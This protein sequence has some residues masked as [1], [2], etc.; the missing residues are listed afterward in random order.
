MQRHVRRSLFYRKPQ[1]N[2]YRMFFWV[3]IILAG[4][5]FVIGNWNGKVRG[6]FD[7]IPTA[8]RTAESFTLEGDAQFNSGQIEA[9][10]LAYRRATDVDP[11]N[12]QVWAKLARIQTYSSALKTTDQ[13]RRSRLQD[14]LDSANHAYNL[15]PDDSTVRAIRAFVLDWNA[16]STL[17]G[18]ER[19]QQL[20]VQAEQEAAAA[21]QLDNK[22]TLALA[23]YAE[24]QT[25]QQK[26]TQ[27]EQYMQLAFE[28]Q[29]SDKLM[30]VHRIYAALLE[31]E[32]QYRQAIEEYDKAIAINPNLTFLYLRAGANYRRLA[33]FPNIPRAQQTDLYKQSLDYFAK[34]A[35]INE[36]LGVKDPIPYLSIAKTYSQMGEFFIAARNVMK[37]LE[38]RPG[39]ADIYGQLGIVYF[40][41]RN[42]EGSLGPFK[43][44]IRGCTAVESCTARF[45]RDC[46]PAFGEVGADVQGLPLSQSTVVYYYTYGS[47]LASL[48][49]PRQNYCPDAVNVLTEVRTAFAS[50]STIVRIVDD[51][52]QICALYAQT[53]D[54]SASATAT[55]TAGGTPT[56]PTVQATSTP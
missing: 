48:T 46:D 2:V 39:D 6:P 22:N 31:S 43:C 30:D 5:W 16:D 13:E 34:A 8:T 3:L 49:R 24:I 27:A 32:A 19:S 35:R 4:G 18:A 55:P 37:A 54:A 38:Y 9:A 11:G 50:D 7:P 52:L 10:I 29:D 15:A 26:W 23:F 20:L 47:A 51:G 41:S 36:Q 44:A 40:K 45:E 25:D 42:Y 53:S 14:A 21:F 28:R 1:S 17:V 33:S 56:I 12:A